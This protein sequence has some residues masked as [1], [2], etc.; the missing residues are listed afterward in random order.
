MMKLNTKRSVLQAPKRIWFCIVKSN[1]KSQDMVFQHIIA[2]AFA[3]RSCVLY[4]ANFVQIFNVGSTACSAPDRGRVGGQLTSSWR[5]KMAASTSS[6]FHDFQLVSF[7]AFFRIV[8][9]VVNW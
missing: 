9:S 8:V 3:W 4:N 7:P 2:P 5:H 1:Q 6:I